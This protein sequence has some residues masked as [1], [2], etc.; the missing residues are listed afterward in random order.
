MAEASVKEKISVAF[1]ICLRI[2]AAAWLAF[3]VSVVPLY[4]WRLYWPNNEFGEN[5]LLSVIGLAF[6]F[7]F[8]VLFQMRDDNF[9]RYGVKDAVCLGLGGVTMYIALWLVAYL[10]SKNNYLVAALGYHLSSLL[11]VSADGQPTF[12]G[13]IASALIFGVMY[14]IALLLGWKWG[15]I[16][17]KQFLK[18]LK[19]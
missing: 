15:R 5:L 16:R 1:F 17:K 6:G 3:V 8:L 10:P 12:L 4:A 2:L 11:F 9:S 19:R 7:L 13:S 14:F 18:D